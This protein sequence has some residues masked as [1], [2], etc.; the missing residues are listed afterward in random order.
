MH[1]PVASQ[2]A[3]VGLLSTLTHLPSRPR[4]LTGTVDVVF[5]TFL[6]YQSMIEG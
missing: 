4:V 6:I 2:A 5:I 3:P 1:A